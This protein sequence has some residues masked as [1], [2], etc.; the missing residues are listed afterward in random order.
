MTFSALR[1][2]MPSIGMVRSMVIVYVTSS[3]HPG[4]RQRVGAL[5][6]LLH[7]PLHQDQDTF[8]RPS[9]SY[10]YANVVVLHRAGVEHEVDPLARP[11]SRL[12]TT[13]TRFAAATHWG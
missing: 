9:Q 3:G 2:I 11:S 4:L 10:S 12:S 5:L 7:L 13:S 6:P 8:R 1:L